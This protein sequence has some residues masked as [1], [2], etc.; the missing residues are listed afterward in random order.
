[1]GRYLTSEQHRIVSDAVAEAEDLTSGEIVTVLADRSDGYSD[2]VLTWAALAS[3]TA[4]SVF[5]LWADFLLDQLHWLKGGRDHGWTIGETISH[6]LGQSG[7]ASWRE[8]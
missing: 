6:D 1:M 4:M 8:R 2:I 3:F 5:G 7:R